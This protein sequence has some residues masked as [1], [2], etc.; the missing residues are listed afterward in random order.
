MRLREERAREGENA[1]SLARSSATPPL[2][3]SSLTRRS[4]AQRRSQHTEA[5]QLQLPP[6]PPSSTSLV[7]PSPSSHRPFH[8]SSPRLPPSLSLPPSPPAVAMLKNLFG[9]K[10]PKDKFSLENL[11]SATSRGA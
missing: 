8:P 3:L 7:R 2:L 6:S 11:K 5:K 10:K 1:S 9:N 4:H